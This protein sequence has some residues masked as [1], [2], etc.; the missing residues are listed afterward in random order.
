MLSPYPCGERRGP[1]GEVLLVADP[2]FE[3]AEEP[4]HVLA[5][6]PIL[7]EGP[8]WRD[9]PAVRGPQTVTIAFAQSSPR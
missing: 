8:V 7:C 5:R 4:R 9:T 6:T 3:L 2:C 1:L